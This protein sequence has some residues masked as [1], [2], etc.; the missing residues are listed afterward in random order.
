MIALTV[1]FPRKSSRTSTHA[2]SVPATPLITAIA[3]DAPKL[4]FRAATACGLETTS[5][6][7]ADPSFVDSQ[8]S[9]AI[10]R[11]TTIERY[12]TTKPRE[13]AVALSLGA[14]SGRTLP[15]VSTADIYVPTPARLAM[16]TQMPLSGSNHRLSTAFQ[17]PMYL[18]VILKI[19]G[20]RGYCLMNS[21]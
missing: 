1:L 17:P 7:P 21:W 12:A 4:S 13:R 3:N 20:R 19:P 18:S 11:A 15:A 5:Q 14:L 2:I 10:G 6:K 16:P 9:A 8:I